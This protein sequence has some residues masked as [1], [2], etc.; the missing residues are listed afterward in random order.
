[1][2]TYYELAEAAAET[3]S[4]VFPDADDLAFADFIDEVLASLA[5]AFQEVDPR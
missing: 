2:T 5:E 1:M 4:P 3:L